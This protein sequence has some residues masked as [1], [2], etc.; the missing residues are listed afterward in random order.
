[1]SFEVRLSFSMGLT[2]TLRVP[3]GTKASL[4]AHVEHVE[5]TL[6]LKRVQREGRGESYWDHW[7]K[8]FRQG[9]PDVD[10]KLLCAT[11]ERHNRWVDRL[12]H[13]LE[14]WAKAPPKPSEKLTP[15]DAERFW[16]ATQK[17]KVDPD[18]WTEDYY[19]ARM[20]EIY[21]AMRGREAGGAI[22]DAKVLTPR[23]AA[24]VINLFEQYLDTHDIRLDVPKGCDYLLPSSAHEGGYDWCEHCGAIDP[25]DSSCRRRKCPV[26]EE[27]S[28]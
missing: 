28:T 8:R 24:S 22:F 25:N 14:E 20:D 3:V 23:Q 12:W 13:D 5:T 18:R 10:A 1:M 17:L 11:V 21:E 26:R 15:G 16:H 19:R 27:R 9:F 6:G 2:K 4:L 7:D